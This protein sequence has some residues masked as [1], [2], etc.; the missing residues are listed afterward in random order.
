MNAAQGCSSWIREVPGGLWTWP[1]GHVLFDE[2]GVPPA[3]ETS[4]WDACS[5]PLRGPAARSMPGLD[6]ARDAESLGASTVCAAAA[7]GTTRGMCCYPRVVS[8]G[9]CRSAR[10][11]M[12]YVAFRRRGAW[13]RRYLRSPAD[14]FWVCKMA[15][16]QTSTAWKIR[17]GARLDRAR[18]AE[19]ERPGLP[20]GRGVWAHEKS[21]ARDRLGAPVPAGVATARRPRAVRP[22]LYRRVPQATVPAGLVP[23]RSA[24]SSRGCSAASRR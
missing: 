16:P 17:A 6:Y 19:A 21:G 9:A 11:V 15:T 12:R 8:L 14:A 4:G 22:G 7:A 2:R 3:R 23:L 13:C 20:R 5:M 24:D 1:A 10:P 18:G